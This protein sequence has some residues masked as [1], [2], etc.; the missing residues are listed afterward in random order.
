MGSGDDDQNGWLPSVKQFAA[1]IGVPAVSLTALHEFA[2]R[3]HVLALMLVV[4]YWMLL[5]VLRFVGEVAD[6]LRERWRKPAADF[7][8]RY[9]ALRVS[10][11]GP[12]YRKGLRGELKKVDTGG[13]AKL[14]KTTPLLSAVYVDL[15]LAGRQPNATS[16]DPIRDRLPLANTEGRSI[17]ELLEDADAKVLVVLGAP[18]TGKTTLLR[19]AAYQM[20]QPAFACPRFGGRAIPILLYFRQHV[21]AIIDDP[22]PSLADLA[23]CLTRF[24]PPSGWFESRLRDGKCVVLLDGL[25][26]IARTED[27]DTVA[28]WVTEQVKRYTDNHFVITS[29]PSGYTA[30]IEGADVMQ[31]RQLTEDQIDQLVDQWYLASQEWSPEEARRRAAVLRRRIRG[32]RIL[33]ELA[34]NPLLLTMIVI[35][36]RDGDRDLPDRRVELYKDIG[37]DARIG[38]NLTCP[39]GWVSVAV[40]N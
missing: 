24:Q 30:P 4:G 18:G 14:P 8:D 36:H 34:A 16:Q 5:F 26:E 15:G 11:F 17:T 39:T 2:G 3:H 12:H 25:D 7:I 38:D 37:T 13:L 31:V 23:E 32:H 21:T 20:C 9:V 40:A 35:V 27:R 10:R 1:T 29:R 19:H 6:S 33:S 22:Q 28:L